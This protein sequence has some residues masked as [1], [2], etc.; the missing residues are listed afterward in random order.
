MVV[1]QLVTGDHE[2]GRVV[3][4]LAE[5]VGGFAGDEEPVVATVPSDGPESFE[6]LHAA[7]PTGRREASGLE[8]SCPE[9]SSRPGPGPAPVE[10][11]RGAR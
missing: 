10:G 7:Q 4:E 5:A 8:T 3:V 1:E 11:R 6:R 2:R 9:Q